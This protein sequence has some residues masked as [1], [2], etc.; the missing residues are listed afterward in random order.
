[1]QSEYNSAVNKINADKNGVRKQYVDSQ[2]LKV[3]NSGKERSKNYRAVVNPQEEA[4][5]Y[6]SA[7]NKTVA[8]GEKLDRITAN[9]P[10]GDIVDNFSY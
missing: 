7:Y 9:K 6:M 5:E 8:R 2:K 4:R 10:K 1:M 3:V